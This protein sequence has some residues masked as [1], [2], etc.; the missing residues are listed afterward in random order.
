MA[1]PLF[2]P[3][4][5]PEMQRNLNLWEKFIENSQTY[6]SDPEC[7]YT[8]TQI[9]LLQKLFQKTQLK[10]TDDVL[11]EGADDTSDLDIEVESRKLYQEIKTFRSNLSIDDVSEKASMFRVASSLLEKLLEIM[12]RSKGVKQ[13]EQFQALII[14]TMDRYLDPQQKS[15]FVEEIN[16]LLGEK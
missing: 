7:P 2:Y 4:F 5:T 1:N 3:E 10:T 12:E 11:L 9:L 8:E 13:F 16:N 6:L 14:N 15:E